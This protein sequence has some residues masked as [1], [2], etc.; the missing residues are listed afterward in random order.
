MSPDPIRFD[1]GAA[2]ERFMGAWS[3]SAGDRFLEWLAPDSGLSWLDVGCGN[4]AFTERV[5]AVARPGAVGGIDPSAGQLAYARGRPVLDR[6]DLRQGD[7]MALPWPAASFDVAVM[8]LVIFFVPEPARG[9]AEMVRVVRPGGLVAAYAWDMVAGGFPYAPLL[10]ELRAMGLDVPGPPHPEMSRLDALADLW[11]S[12][13]LD[14]LATTS[15]AVDRT[16]ADVDDYWT[17]I[18]GSPSVGATVTGLPP[19]ARTELLA[20]LRP[21]LPADAT[22]RIAVR[23]V[24]NAVKG[25]VPGTPV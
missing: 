23:A 25:R 18:Q 11:Q 5:V 7:A 2:Y 8:P 6:A 3:Q 19:A 21:H 4:G 1:D 17:T 14:D 24:A 16:F 22:G 15:I 10:A 12:A 13:G 9:V 20:R